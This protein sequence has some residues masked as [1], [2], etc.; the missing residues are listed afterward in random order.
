M[1]GAVGR[2]HEGYNPLGEIEAAEPPALSC[3]QRWRG[4]T[5]SLA[6][7]AGSAVLRAANFSPVTNMLGSVFAG[8]AA[9]TA[10]SSGRSGA[11]MAKFRRL[12][13][14]VCGYMTFFA[15]SQLFAIYYDREAEYQDSRAIV[16]RDLSMAL[17]AV[18][19]ETVLRRFWSKRAIR[20]E[21]VSKNSGA[22]LEPWKILREPFASSVKIV[23]AG[24]AAWVSLEPSTDPVLRAIASSAAGFFLSKVLGERVMAHL[25]GRIRQCVNAGDQGEE[26]RCRR[27][28]MALSTLS[29]FEFVA[30]V[31]WT[32]DPASPER[33][34][35]LPIVSLAIGL[36]EGFKTQAITERL[37]H[38]PVAELDELQVRE[39]R[40]LFNE[41]I[42]PALSTAGMVGFVIWQDRF[43]LENDNDRIALGAMLATFLGT[44]GIAKLVE[45]RWNPEHRS[46][47]LDTGMVLCA[48]SPS[49]FG[50]HPAIFY[51]LGMNC[52]KINSETIAEA[53]FSHAIVSLVAWGA[54][55][56]AIASELARTTSKRNG[57]MLS[58]FP[59]VLV[60]TLANTAR[61]AA[62][63]SVK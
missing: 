8:A 55:G 40:S 50:A 20:I 12:A 59:L 47:A 17:A 18:G 58:D 24:G 38:V 30:L 35:Q 1:A 53:P 7:A 33:L 11:Q 14:N 22:H 19:L 63:G 52:L 36:V 34:K 9:S 41:K 13:G 10:I 57:N 25:N 48:G 16:I 39:E 27:I 61:A 2:P 31:P 21:S 15:L 5:V 42:W 60:T 28:Q 54:G 6:A 51:V 32:A 43:V 56:A 26:T 49:F 62:T 45:W 37:T 29:F 46:R 23:V 4:R 3:W 44:L